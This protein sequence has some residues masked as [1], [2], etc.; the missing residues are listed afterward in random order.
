MSF[1]SVRNMD[2]WIAFTSRLKVKFSESRLFV[3]TLVFCSECE[4]TELYP[5]TVFPKLN[6]EEV[7]SFDNAD[8]LALL[9]YC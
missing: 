6:D 2:I 7:H 5:A 4:L 9:S 1:M 8:S 3:R